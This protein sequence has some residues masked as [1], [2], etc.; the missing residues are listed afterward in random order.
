MDSASPLW[1]RRKRK[2]GNGQGLMIFINN[3][4]VWSIRANQFTDGQPVVLG[5]LR[6]KISMSSSIISL[7]IAVFCDLDSYLNPVVFLRKS[8]KHFDRHLRNWIHIKIKNWLA[9]KSLTIHFSTAEPIPLNHVGRIHA[10]GHMRS[11]RHQISVVLMSPIIINS[12][13]EFWFC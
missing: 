13:E 4:Y 12:F 2:V 10:I 3:Q 1:R 8:W 11:S 6:I 9:V 5:I 7:N